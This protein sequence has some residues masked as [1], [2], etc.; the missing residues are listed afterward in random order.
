MSIES[1]WRKINLWKLHFQSIL[2]FALSN[3]GILCENIQWVPQ[4]AFCLS[5]GSSN[6]T[7]F[8]WKIYIIFKN[9]SEIGRKIFDSLNQIFRQV[10]EN[11]ILLV[12]RTFSVKK[13]FLVTNFYWNISTTLNERISPFCL[14]LFSGS[15]QLHSMFSSDQLKELHFL[16][17]SY[18][19]SS[20][21]DIEQ[22][23][24]GLQKFF[25]QGCEKFISL[26]LG[27]ILEKLIFLERKTIFV[28]FPVWQ[29]FSNRVV[30]TAFCVFKE[31]NR[32]KV[33]FRKSCFF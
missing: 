20:L 26:V 21:L 3:T 2:A 17:N 33:F 13:I 15:S 24:F 14:K 22:T 9:F 31:T 30:K 8:A 28:S 11:C 16:T 23:T 19:F 7:L 1:L 27:N 6:A 29:K 25:W 5:I 32:G 12:Q 18:L 10:W 4:I